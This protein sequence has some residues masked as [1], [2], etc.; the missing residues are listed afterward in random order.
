MSLETKLLVFLL[1][2]CTALSGTV[3]LL[4]VLF[5]M[6]T[7]PYHSNIWFALATF[8]LSIFDL[9]IV[10]FRLKVLSRFTQVF[11]TLLLFASGTVLYYRVLGA[12]VPSSII[13]LV[14][15]VVLAGIV[16]VA[17][18]WSTLGT[19]LYV[20]SLPIIDLEFFPG[21]KRELASN[22]REVSDRSAHPCIICY[23]RNSDTLFLPCAHLICCHTCG[24]VLSSCPL[25][26]RPISVLKVLPDNSPPI[27]V[28]EGAGIG[29]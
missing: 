16:L 20:H 9:F 3:F 5:L 4:E 19:E 22:S 13:S 2:V 29:V 21:S 27:I 11:A 12:V 23:T 17:L 1:S 25:C 18:A 26:R 14:D 24:A 28:E 10:I 15:N 6:G 8:V 7:F